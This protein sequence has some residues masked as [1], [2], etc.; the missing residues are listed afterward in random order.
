MKLEFFDRFLEKPTNIKFHENP[1]IGSR[2]VP[3]GR[4]DGRT[5]GQTDRRKDKTKPAVAFHNFVNAPKNAEYPYK[6]NK[7]L[8]S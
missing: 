6:S 2:V 3:G 8:T 5:D 4:K 1:F 7:R